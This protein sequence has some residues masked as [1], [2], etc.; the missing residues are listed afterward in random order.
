MNKQE[1]ENKERYLQEKARFL[2]MELES[3]IRELTR[4]IEKYPITGAT[5]LSSLEYELIPLQQR[6]NALMQTIENHKSNQQ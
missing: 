2:Q 3:K 4:K 1:H 6:I 5:V